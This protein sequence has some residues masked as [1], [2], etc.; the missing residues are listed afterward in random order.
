MEK[1]EIRQLIQPYITVDTIV[2]V[3]MAVIVLFLNLWIGIALLLVVVM[4]SVYHATITAGKAVKQL[5]EMRS[6]TIAESEEITRNFV[7]NSPVLMCVSD[8]DGNVRWASEGFREKISDSEEIGEYIPKEEL[9]KLFDN[10]K[11]EYIANIGDAKYRVTA[12]A[13]D[14]SGHSTRMLYF[15]DITASEIVRNLFKDSRPCL[16][17]VHIDNFEEL[18][19]SCPIENQSKLI[20]DIEQILKDW[21]ESLEASFARVKASQYSIIFENKY[22]DGLKE[23]KFDVMEKVHSIETE[24]DFPTTISI[25]IGAG[26]ASFAQLQDY[27]ND[28]MELAYGRGGDQTVIMKPGS[29]LEYFGGALSNLERRNKGKS[30]I[31]AHALTRLINESGKVM[32]MGHQR[33]DMDCL[34]GAIGIA[35]FAQALKKKAYIILNNPGEAVDLLHAEAVKTGSFEFINDEMAMVLADENTLLVVVDTHIGP[36]TECPAL[37][38]K[39]KRLVVI[40]HHRKS[41]NAIENTLLTY[42]EPFA[43]SASE[44]VSEILQYAGGNLEFSKFEMDALLAGITL[45]TKNFTVNTGARTF[46]T[47]SWLRRNGASSKN[48]AGFFKMRLDFFQKKVNMIASAEV[49]GNEIA[50]AYTKDTDPSMQVLTGQTA[51][52]LL[53][54]RGINAVFVAG[55]L[56]DKGTTVSARSNGQFNVQV[57]M[58]K[59]GGGGHLNS[60]AAQLTESPE[61]AIQKIVEILREEK[62][63]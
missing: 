40:D 55:S 59:L 20:G 63:I 30:R 50:V 9:K 24:A 43:S 42:M 31:I 6:R 28:A 54:M 18:L 12:S 48:V 25:G 38:D 17:Y 32:V 49:L 21:A 46:E 16:A 13:R 53:E 60:A 27:A 3:L 29:E 57:I 56:S 1:K 37:L 45:D 34:G 8:E 39:C 61:E 35:A 14:E 22:L 11:Y 23:N 26:G 15:E 10:E 44:Q 47:A 5:S 41:A 36:Q 52:E 4:L 33:P 58:E 2:M 62:L 19:A 7:D 51:D